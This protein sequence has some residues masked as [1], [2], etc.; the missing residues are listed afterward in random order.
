VADSVEQYAFDV[1]PG[2]TAYQIGFQIIERLMSQKLIA[3]DLG[4]G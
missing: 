1:S 4:F 2:I 3:F